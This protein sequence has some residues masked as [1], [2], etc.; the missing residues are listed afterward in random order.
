MFLLIKISLQS[1]FYSISWVPQLG[2]PWRLSISMII[3]L[4]ILYSRLGRK[5]LNIF[6]SYTF[7]SCR[8]PTALTFSNKTCFNILNEATLFCSN[9]HALSRYCEMRTS[10]RL[11]SFNSCIQ[12]H[13]VDCVDMFDLKLRLQLT[14]EAKI[15]FEGLDGLV[16]SRDCVPFPSRHTTFLGGGGVAGSGLRSLSKNLIHVCPSQRPIIS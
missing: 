6:Q 2:S 13:P 1:S 10:K 8:Y 3:N 15:Q 7:N 16:Q 9:P 14:E 5:K 4:M 12:K 11:R